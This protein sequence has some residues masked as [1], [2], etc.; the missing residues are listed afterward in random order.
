MV[1]V[2]AAALAIERFAADYF[3]I[4]TN[5]LTQYVTAAGRDI[6]AVAALADPANPAVLR[7]IAEVARHG[8]AHRHR[9]QRVRRHGGGAAPAPRCSRAGIR[10]LSLAP[11]RG[12]AR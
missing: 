4:G 9:G 8:A 12:R 10:A 7:L 2:P 11:N 1:E 3:S 5:D 6:G